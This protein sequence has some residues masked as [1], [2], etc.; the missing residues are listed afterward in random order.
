MQQYIKTGKIDD[1]DD[2][3]FMGSSNWFH[4]SN[5]NYDYGTHPWVNAVDILTLSVLGV[6]LSIAWPVTAI[7][8]IVI[9]YAKVARVRFAR[10]KEFIDRL[11]GEHVEAT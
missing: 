2:S 3:W 7:A 5:N 4:G 1:A 6:I 9:T 8:T 11:Q 10:K